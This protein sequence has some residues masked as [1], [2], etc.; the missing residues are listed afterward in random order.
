[1]PEITVSVI[2]HG[3]GELILP[4]LQQ[5]SSIA[6]VLPLRVIVTENMPGTGGALVPL[7]EGLYDQLIANPQPKGFGANHN[8]AFERC[9]TPFFCVIN[10]D[11][12]LDG[13]P[14]SG[15]CE[16]LRAAP[17]IAAPCVMNSAGSLEDSARRVPTPARLWRRAVCGKR[18]ADYVPHGGVVTVDWV[19]GMLMMFDTDVFRRLGGFD[20]RFHM[21]CEDVDVCLRA[22][23]AGFSVQ[24]ATG[25][26]VVHDAQR[27]SH[28]KWKYR[29]WHVESM[30]RLLLSRS[31]LDFLCQRRRAG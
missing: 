16:V 28:R 2:S 22:H 27:E 21:Y 23:L 7:G 26:R 12:R 17:G 14:F 10:P 30:A 11:I 4:L 31:Y 18:Q 24:W 25:V 29:A 5:L 8:A 1:M 20:D 15:L 9:V 3:Q 6:K 19:A 13:E